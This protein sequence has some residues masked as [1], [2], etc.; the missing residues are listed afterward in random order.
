MIEAFKKIWQFAGAE[1]KNINRS[2]AVSFLNAVLQ[3]FQVG[4]IYF[5]VLALTDGSRGGGTAWLALGLVLV[6][7]FGGA[8][9]ASRA[10]M[11][12][13]HAG[14]F[15]ADDRRVAIA[16][17]LKSVPM[18]F[19]N[20]NSLGQVAGV[21]TTVVG[22][23]E[24]MVLVNILSGL[25][26]TAVFAVMILFF[27]WHIGLIAIIGIA[28]YFAVVSAMEKKSVAIAEGT[29]RSQTALVEAVLETIQGMS[30]VK[31]FNLTGKGDK[32]LQ[33]DGA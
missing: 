29:Q 5:V 26:T 9:A 10:K 8:L 14:Y 32:K 18:G 30:V 21:C 12:Q 33:I 11:Y 15:M 19:F 16:D 25:L 6:S 13:T 4:A 23:I 27:D 3:M 20:A 22:G 17:R 31:A 2:V 28:L 1:R 7:V 24:G